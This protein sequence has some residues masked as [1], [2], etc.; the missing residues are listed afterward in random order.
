[1]EAHMV[2][3][4]TDGLEIMVG[5]DIPEGWVRDSARD[6]CVS[7]IH[8]ETSMTIDIF[9]TNLE[10]PGKCREAYAQKPKDIRDEYG[11]VLGGKRYSYMYLPKKSPKS[12]AEKLEKVAK[13]VYEIRDSMK[14]V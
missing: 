12:S 4:S 14:V 1:M 7:Y 3:V 9:A 10:S 13:E 6:N 5:I 11:S 2:T 8:T